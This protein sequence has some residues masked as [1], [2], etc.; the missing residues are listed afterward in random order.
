[1][2]SAVSVPLYETWLLVYWEETGLAMPTTGRC[3]ID[4]LYIGIT[5]LCRGRQ[6]KKY[7]HFL[8]IEEAN[9]HRK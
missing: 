1:M 8:G 2:A 9:R 3:D 4:S 7:L 6:T 5:S